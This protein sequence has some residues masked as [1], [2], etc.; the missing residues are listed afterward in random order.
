LQDAKNLLQLTNFQRADTFIAFLNGSRTRAFFLASAD[1]RKENP[2]GNCQMFSIDTLGD[3]LGRGIRQ[4]THFNPGT[5]P[6][7]GIA[8][9][10]VTNDSFP[11]GCNIGSG[12]Y[13]VVF[14][15]PMT[16]AVVFESSCDPLGA[17]HY[18][19]QLL[20]MR[21]DGSGLRQLTDAA[22]WTINPGREQRGR[23]P[24]PIRLLGGRAVISARRAS[25]PS[26]ASHLRQ[27]QRES[28]LDV[29]TGSASP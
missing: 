19:G 7:V 29:P 4:I 2:N 23:A 8:G 5:V 3:T 25:A 28:V 12:V 11:G 16:K 24:R 27:T 17:N 26:A 14:Q 21:A 22:G 15:Y 20:A 9:C 13:R 18:G 10:F 6:P 1:P